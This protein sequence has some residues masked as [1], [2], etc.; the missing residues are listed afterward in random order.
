MLDLVPIYDG[1][2]Q[3]SS[4]PWL[5]NFLAKALLRRVHSIEET[6][7][8]RG[9]AKYAGVP[10]H[11]VVALNTF[12]DLFSGCSS[13]GARVSDAGNGHESGIV[14]F[15][16]LDWDMDPLRKLIICVNYVR[17]GE[18]VAR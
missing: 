6:K 4:I 18:I 8:I 16:G 15:R 5:L 11:L 12:L 13:G 9:I 10:L 7:E 3:L 17:A 2:L 14:H 1:L